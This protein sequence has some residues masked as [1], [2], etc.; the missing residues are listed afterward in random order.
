MKIKKDEESKLENIV[1][2]SENIKLNKA[3]KLSN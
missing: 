2:Q 1:A 3:L